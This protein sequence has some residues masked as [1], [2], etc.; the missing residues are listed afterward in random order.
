MVGREGMLGIELSLGASAAPLRT[1]AR[2]SGA[3][4]RVSADAFE[5][6]LARGTALQRRL[7]LYAFSLM[8]RLGIAAACQRFHAVGPRLASW[9]L[10]SMDRAQGKGLKATQ[11]TIAELLGVRRESVTEEA[12]KLAKAG[13]ISYSRGHI[14]LLERAQLEALA[15]SCYRSSSDARPPIVPGVKRK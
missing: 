1:V 8:T 2:L 6:E 3:A 11:K 12:S 4:W 15:C 9:L 5:C 14:A 13:C 10:L 7:T